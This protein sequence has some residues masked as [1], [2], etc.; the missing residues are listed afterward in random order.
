MKKRIGYFVIGMFLF[1]SIPQ[2][3]SSNEGLSDSYNIEN[4]I[5][6]ESIN[7]ILGTP[8]GINML[9]LIEAKGGTLDLNNGKT[10]TLPNAEATLFAGSKKNGV[11]YDLAWISLP[12]KGNFLVG[13][14]S[15]INPLSL[16]NSYIKLYTVSGKVVLFQNMEMKI[17]NNNY[18]FQDKD[19]VTNSIQVEDIVHSMVDTCTILLILG[20]LSGG[21]LLIAYLL[22]CL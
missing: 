18:S 15:F 13:V 10:I 7:Y 6:P 12:D 5:L 2:I 19:D 3:A 4:K 16:V 22:T 8:A 21:L 17:L 1:L 11:K 14:E 9:N 20:I